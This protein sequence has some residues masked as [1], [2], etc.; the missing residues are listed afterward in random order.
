MPIKRKELKLATKE[1]GFEIICDIYPLLEPEPYESNVLKHG[2]HDQSTHGSWAIQ[3]AAVESGGAPG[4][5]KY[6][7]GD[8]AFESVRDSSLGEPQYVEGAVANF[9]FWSGNYAGR[10]MSAVLMGLDAPDATGGETLDPLYIS[11]LKTGKKSD[12]ATERQEEFIQQNL[13]DTA[14]LMVASV[15]SEPTTLPLYR[16][17][18]VASDDPITSLKTGD[19]FT[20]PLS[21]FSYDK[22]VS[23]NFARPNQLFGT[24]PRTSVIF[25]METGAKGASNTDVENS[26]TQIKVGSKWTSVP[27]E[28]ISQ[29]KYVV[30]GVSRESMSPDPAP[31]QPSQSALFVKIKHQEVFNIKTG[32]Y[33]S[34]R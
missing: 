22:S 2:E 9:G 32:T 3:N 4:I 23:E 13:E 7:Y 15:N 20:I 25:Q 30:T 24:A 28:V 27:D 14:N 5:T 11:A 6:T 26:N 29:G 21:S 34:V 1:L 19:N 31:N 17:M 12:V 10:N 18:T 8:F 33:E 16:G